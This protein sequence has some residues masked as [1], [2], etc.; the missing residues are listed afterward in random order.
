MPDPRDFTRSTRD[1][2][3]A[4]SGNQCAFPGCGVTFFKVD[5]NTKLSNICH[6]EAANQGGE[7]YNP[8]SNDEYRRSYENLIL[9]CPN[10][11]KETND[12]EKYTVDVLKGMKRCHEAKFL[13]PTAL[14][15]HVSSLSTVINLM[16]DT[17]IENTFD[18]IV[19]AP[20]IEEKI[21]YNNVNVYRSLIDEYAQYNSRLNQLYNEIEKQGSVK[22]SVILQSIRSFY[23]KEKGNKNI[24]DIRENA[25][26]IIE[27][28]KNKMWKT[29]EDSGKLSYGLPYDV[30]E[31]NI[32]IILVDAF[33]RCKILE[34]PRTL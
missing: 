34:E 22:K 20:D 5:T 21:H 30:I 14:R 16:G 7:R 11:H 31:I 18:G 23:L 17:F 25:D 15:K 26:A 12:T 3:Y 6:I 33:M 8:D 2:L 1:R 28:I 27:S 9:L 24:N 13:N 10:H 32:L 19:V 4:L 29:V